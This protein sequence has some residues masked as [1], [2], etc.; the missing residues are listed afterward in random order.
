MKRRGQN[1]GTI[2][3]EK[4]GRWVA[5]ITLG[6][7]VKNGKRRRIRKKFVGATRR[8][9]QQR[10]TAALREQ[11]TGGSV[12]MQ[13]DTVGGFLANW[14]ES[15]RMK[16]RA[17]STLASYK[18]ITETYIV[19][20]LGTVPL[21]KLTQR[22]IND[23]MGRKLESGL[24]TRTVQLCHAVL[25]SALSKAEKDGLVGRNVAKLAEPPRQESR[26]PIEPL[27][28]FEAR[29]F[30]SALSGHRLEALY[31]VA[32]AIGLR[33]GEA[34]GL[35]WQDLDVV[36]GSLSVCQTVKRILGKGLIVES[37]GK[38][39]GSLRMLPL[40][41]FAVRVLLEHQKR[42]A[43]ERA[44]AGDAWQDHDLVFPSNIGTPLEPRNLVRHFHATLEKVKI[45]RRRFHDLRHTA[46]SLLIAQGAT[47]HEVKEILGHTQIRLTSDLYGH[48]FM[49]AKREAV[50]RMDSILD[51]LAPSV[52]PFAVLGRPN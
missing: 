18:W 10:L 28:A 48:A 17:E 46:A 39:K 45:D 30:L 40:P 25:R 32:L 13:R 6:Y 29:L 1:E 15:T 24:S 21:T 33:R 49:A 3:E 52:A 41:A 20:E 12:P 36:N 16:E 50:D 7:E 11:Q 4:P 42:Q 27:T 35:R 8:A 14:L 31:S 44:F 47:L 43:V 26:P 34:L 23:F 5:A 37:K 19:P 51:P 22:E 2:F 38:T 9:V